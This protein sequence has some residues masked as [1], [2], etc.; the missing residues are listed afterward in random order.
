MDFGFFLRAIGPCFNRPDQHTIAIIKDRLNETDRGAD[1]GSVV[2]YRSFWFLDCGNHAGSLRGVMM[3]RHISPGCSYAARDAVHVQLIAWHRRSIAVRY[4]SC[5][6]ISGQW[7]SAATT[8]WPCCT[9]EPK[10]WDSSQW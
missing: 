3:T 4:H 10:N 6:G 1:R 7:N 8:R 9:I 5:K 2:R